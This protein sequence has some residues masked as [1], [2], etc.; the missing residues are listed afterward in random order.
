MLATLFR[1]KA[2]T[3]NR[4]ELRQYLSAVD[5]TLL[6]IGAII[7]AGI[8]IL[9]GI[10]AATK[11]GPALMVSF[12]LAGIACGC[13]ALAYAELAASIG[14]IG[15][16]YSYAYVGFGEI[17]AWIIGWD[18]LLEY[19]ISCPTVAIGWSA[20][21]NNI[22][23][24]L[25]YQLIPE[26]VKGPFEGGQI[27]LFAVGITLFITLLLA[28]GIKQSTVFNRLIVYFKL[29]VI[30]IF[31]VLAL[32]HFDIANWQPFFP[33]GF[34]G[35]VEGAAII[36]F[37]YIGFD[38]LSTAVEETIEPQK[39]LP[40]GIITSLILCTLIY[41]LVSGALTGMMHFSKLN[42]ASPVAYA[43]LAYNY[44]VAASIVALG[45]VAGLTTV[46]LVMFYGF[47][48]VFLAMARDGL[49]PSFLAKVSPITHTPVRIILSSG[50]VMIL[51]A[52]TLP[53]HEAAELVNIG[54]LA[55]FTLVCG[56]VIVLRYT[57]PD[58]KRPFKLPFNPFIPALG[59]VLSLYLMFSLSAVTWARFFI[60]MG[61][62][63][64]IYFLYS[65]KR[66]HLAT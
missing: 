28:I 61:I 14:G 8:F 16:A 44:R 13:S 12:M 25:G 29:A 57:Q 46:I 7:G 38:A 56:G 2:I 62:G 40:I 49:L 43:L 17:I 45:A 37:A 63:C 34:K 11:A 18:L 36:F 15:S 23:N 31:L 53:I 58:L 1:K 52:A 65:R 50:L 59:A 47:S 6:G 48:R 33:F 4:Q 41:I 19:G 66:S 35:V 3:S 30:F 60:W 39:N 54:T 32:K 64:L 5:L 42:V 20:Y 21:A 27:N 51:I 26:L 10:V 55:A 22:L 9:T 24:A